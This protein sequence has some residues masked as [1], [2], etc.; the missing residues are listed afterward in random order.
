MLHYSMYFKCNLNIHTFMWSGS[1]FT[2]HFLTQ[3]WPHGSRSVQS[4][5][6]LNCSIS[7]WQGLFTSWLQCG[8]V[9][10]TSVMQSTEAGSTWHGS[11]MG[12]PHFNSRCT[13]IIHG[14]QVVLHINGHLCPSTSHGALWKPQ[15]Y[16]EF[17]KSSLH[18]ARNTLHQIW[19]FQTVLI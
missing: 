12:C 5:E 10:F 13:G 4:T 17:K 8:S 2:W 6:H 16:I 7:M 11:L 15:V 3:A 19:T 9:T 18:I 1:S 14:L